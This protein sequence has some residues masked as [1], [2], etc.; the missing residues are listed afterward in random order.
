MEKWVVVIGGYSVYE[1]MSRMYLEYGQVTRWYQAILGAMK[2]TD[3]LNKTTEGTYPIRKLHIHFLFPD[4]L[5]IFRRPQCR[6]RFSCCISLSI[7]C[8][9]SQERDCLGKRPAWRPFWAGNF[10]IGD[11]SKSQLVEIR[12]LIAGQMPIPHHSPPAGWALVT[13]DSKSIEWIL[14]P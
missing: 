13:A 7:L 5:V 8:I 4:D 9:H 11:V 3:F 12:N 10:Q 6:S 1:Q 2:A 14:A